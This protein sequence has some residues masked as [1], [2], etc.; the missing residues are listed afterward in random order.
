MGGPVALCSLTTILGYG[1]LVFADNMALQ[2]F[3]RYAMAG[4]F[5]C[6]LAALLVLPAA[7]GLSQKYKE[8]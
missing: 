6:I 4:E 7:L 8:R 3:G 5:S 2:S 1:A